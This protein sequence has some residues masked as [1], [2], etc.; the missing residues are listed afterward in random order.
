MITDLV[1]VSPMSRMVADVARR[2]PGVVDVVYGWP[3]PS[4]AIMLVKLVNVLK[5]IPAFKVIVEDPE[6]G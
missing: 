5:E 6:P 2:V 4:K 1:T 3:L